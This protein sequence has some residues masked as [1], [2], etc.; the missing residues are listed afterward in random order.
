MI[1][2]GSLAEKTAA[3][4]EKAERDQ[5]RIEAQLAQHD[6]DRPSALELEPLVDWKRK[7][8]DLVEDLESAEEVLANA[9]AAADRQVKAAAEAEADRRHAGGDKLAR[10]GEK[11]TLDVMAKAEALRN[12][13]AALEA[14]RAEIDALNKVRG[15]RPLIV[16]GERKLR[17]VPAHVIPAVTRQEQVWQDK[18]GNRCSVLRRLDDG[19]WVPQN[20][21]PWRLETITITNV[22]EKQVPAT[23]PN[24]LAEEIRLVDL[25]GQQTWPPR[26]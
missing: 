10:A 22:R 6:R 3:A 23:M 7:R 8:R 13:L 21:G 1:G 5:V 14:N 9:K 16:D 24:R 18:D 12:A 2:F 17:T 20:P 19:R 26:R 4:V 25:R 11:L 15:D